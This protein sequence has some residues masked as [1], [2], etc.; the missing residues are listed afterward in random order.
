MS[1]CVFTENVLVTIRMFCDA[2]FQ[3]SYAQFCTNMHKLC[4][5]MHLSPL[6]ACTNCA[7]NPPN[8]QK[9]QILL[10]SF[11]ELNLCVALWR[12]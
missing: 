9:V 10:K 4:T 12:R 1:Q 5:N 8:A 3:H 11:H 6:S 2:W 7:Q